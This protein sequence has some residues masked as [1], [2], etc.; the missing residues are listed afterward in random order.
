[1]RNFLFF[2]KIYELSDI[3]PHFSRDELVRRGRI[4]VIDDQEMPLF[5][6]LSK[7]GFSVDHDR[8]G[9]DTSKIERQIYDVIIL[10]HGGVG[11]EFGAEEG[12]ALLRRIKRLAPSAYILAYTSKA[13]KSQHSDFYK[14][15][16][17]VLEKDAGLGDSLKI[18]E[19]ALR[20]SLTVSHLW[21]AAMVLTGLN[22]GARDEIELRKKFIEAVRKR[23]VDIFKK[24]LTGVLHK[25]VEASIDAIFS[26][27]F[28]VAGGTW[29]SSQ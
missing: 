29:T 27:V 20:Q 10:D 3:E 1:M 12:L 4:L 9:N 8:T 25:A 5:K 2:F 26:K 19:D 22:P 7:E 18:I 24:S 21:N 16:D 28:S 15:C 17:N 11:T 13:L 6:S 14:L 23:N